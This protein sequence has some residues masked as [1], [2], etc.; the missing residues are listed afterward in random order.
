MSLNRSPNPTYF[1][2]H[3]TITDDD[4]QVVFDEKMQFLHLDHIQRM[5][6]TSRFHNVH[7]RAMTPVYV[8]THTNLTT[9]R[10]MVL[11]GVTSLVGAFFD[12]RALQSITLPASLTS[13]GQSAFYKCTSLASIELPD[14]LTSIGQLAFQSCT[15]LQ[16]ITINYTG[17]NLSIGPNPFDNC[18]ALTSITINYTG[19]KP[20]TFATAFPEDKRELIHYV[21]M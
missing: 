7:I 19:A 18:T 15:A 8:L 6:D 17:G 9:T 4:Q 11:E 10:T 12:C 13:I 3:V 16:S 2:F 14:S 21:L 20:T 5:Y 1:H